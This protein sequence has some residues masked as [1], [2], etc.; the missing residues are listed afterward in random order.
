[1]ALGL[2]SFSIDTPQYLSGL[3]VLSG[4]FFEISLSDFQRIV[5][6]MQEQI[7]NMNRFVYLV[8]STRFAIFTDNEQVLYFNFH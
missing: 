2:N 6:L 7:P 5:P 4:F 8:G 3:T 1:M